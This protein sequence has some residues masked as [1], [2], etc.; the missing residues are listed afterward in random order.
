MATNRWYDNSTNTLVDFTIARATEV[1]SKFD[2]VANAFDSLQTEF[3]QAV[4]GFDSSVFTVVST[5]ATLESAKLYLAQT[6]GYTLSLPVP[7]A[8]GQWVL[9]ETDSS[10]TVA[11]PVTVSGNGLLINGASSVTLS[12]P[13][14]VAYFTY[15]GSKWEIST[16]GRGPLRTI[17]ATLTFGLNASYILRGTGPFVLPTT[18]SV[19]DWV[20]VF[21]DYD[22]TP[23]AAITISTGATIDSAGTTLKLTESGKRFL[24]VWNGT[25]WHSSLQKVP[26][27]T[28]SVTL[29]RGG[30]YVANTSGV[31]LTL[32]AAPANGTIV[33]LTVLD[34]PGSIVAAGAGDTVDGNASVTLDIPRVT[35]R[36]TYF[37]ASNKWMISG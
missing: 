21:V 30:T 13:D 20:E 6:G 1:E 3:D 24:F 32:P 15:T 2:D 14:L 28:T 11:S 9:V 10:V 23:A 8:T 36:L 17:S 19:G 33:T 26:T 4:T 37:S 25:T 27:I 34:T 35:V 31:T 7:T 5:T 16:S 29:S 12:I 18:A 22:A